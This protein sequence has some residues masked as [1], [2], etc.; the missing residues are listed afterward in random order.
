MTPK[1]YHPR[2]RKDYRSLIYIAIGVFLVAAA[3]LYLLSF[4]ADR[5][6]DDGALSAVPATANYPAPELAL[7]DL[8][9]NPVALSDH[10]GQVVLV[11]NWASWC[12]PC[13]AEMPDLQAYYAEH[14]D[15]GFIVIGIDAGEPEATVRTFVEQYSL[16]FPIWLD[17][18]MEALY[19]FQNPDLPSSYVIDR[20]G[21]VRRHWTG[22]ISIRMLDRYVTPLIER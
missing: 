6:M 22:Q 8:D 18:R 5:T 17:L 7:T 11:N 2:P 16:T 4:Y 20:E 1:R 19:V 12:P 15:E 3:G 13:Q 10:I 14:A 9:G 21:T